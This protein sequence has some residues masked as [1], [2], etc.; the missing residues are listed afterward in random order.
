MKKEE[1]LSE[2][3]RSDTWNDIF[4]ILKELPVKY[5]GSDDCV[6]LSSACSSI[7]EKLGKKL[8]TQN[9]KYLRLVADFDNYKKRAI[10]EKEDLISSTKVN[11]ISP[12]LDID[13]D[14]SIAKKNI[15][16]KETSEG[17]DIILKKLSNFLESMG[18]ETIQTDEYDSD[19]HDVISVIDGGDK[20]I[21]VV[22]KGYSIKNKP[23]R[24]PKV[25]LG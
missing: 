21:D 24:Y 8:E 15:K 4:N 2:I 6:D 11:M 3:N 7:E 13:N 14:I 12:I 9:Q 16:D 22:S 23:F 10:R 17:L 1:T 5:E 19:I 25:V 20:I 18:I